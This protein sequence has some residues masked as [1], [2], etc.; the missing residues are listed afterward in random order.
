MSEPTPIC[1]FCTNLNVPLYQ[2]GLDPIVHICGHCAAQALA[3]TTPQPVRPAPVS[4]EERLAFVPSPKALVAHL[5]Q[6]VVGQELAKRRIALGG[7]NH[8]KRIVDALEPDDPIVS[9]PDLR[10]VRIEKSNI[11]LVGPSGSGK[12]HLVKSLASYLD[13][14]VVIADATSLTEAGYVGDDVES[15]LY[16]LIQAAG[17]D[18]EFAQRGIVY[19]DEIDKLRMSGTGGK[20]MRLGVQNALLKMLEGTV[21]T[22]PPQGGWKHPAQPG[23]PFDT[24]NVL[25]ICGGAFAGLEEIIGKRL[26]RG[27]F[28]FGQQAETTQVKDP[29]RHVLPADL[30]WFGLI[31]EL[32]G[33]LP[34]IAHLAPL[35]VDDL[36]R[37]LT[38]PRGSLI[39]Q[40]RKLVQFHGA[41]LVVT[42]QA[43]KEI[44]SVALERGTGARGLRSVVEEVLEGV[45]FEAEAGVRYV[46]TEVTVRGGKAV[47]RNTSQAAAPLS[48]RM[49]GR[50]KVGSIFSQRLAGRSVI[51]SSVEDL[52]FYLTDSVSG[53]NHEAVLET[54]QGFRGHP[55]LRPKREGEKPIAACAE[56][57]ARR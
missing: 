41:D 1:A 45:L 47:R 21:A 5:D 31:P 50:L 2:G 25:F 46:V 52:C 37:I 32:I 19:I 7:A 33:R 20:D 43:V 6:F 4:R 55:H 51:M 39:A 29:L 16:R 36:A 27:G 24:S 53:C 13:L 28:G 42:D 48:K 18:I 17:G 49:S 38:Q 56:A 57:Q 22:V 44:A 3:Q 34:I 10:N 23:T 9:D 40:Y 14:P 26:G 35:S 30:E 8:V 11:L 12:T 15:L 54:E